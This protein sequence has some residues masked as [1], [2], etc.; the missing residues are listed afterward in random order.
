MEIQVRSVVEELS[1][2]AMEVGL[3]DFRD[4]L[5]TLLVSWLNGGHCVMV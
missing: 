1:G 4:Q 2:I 3:R 5:D